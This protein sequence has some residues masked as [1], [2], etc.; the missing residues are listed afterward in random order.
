L[1]ELQNGKNHFLKVDDQEWPEILEKRTLNGKTY[2]GPGNKFAYSGSIGPRHYKENGLATK[3]P[4]LDIDCNDPDNIKSL[5]RL[6]R[7]SGIGYTWQARE[8]GSPAITVRMLDI[9]RVDPEYRENGILYY[10]NIDTELDI[11]TKPLPDRYGIFKVLKG[12][13]APRIFKFQVSWSKNPKSII[14][15]AGNIIKTGLPTKINQGISDLSSLYFDNCH[16]PP[17]VAWDAEGKSIE[18]KKSIKGNI[19][20]EEVIIPEDFDAWPITV[21]TDVEYQVGASENDG[22]IYNSS[23]N[24][25]VITLS[26]GNSGII[27]SLYARWTNIA[28]PQNT[29]ILAAKIQYK[30]YANQSSTTCRTRIY[31][32]DAD[33]AANPTDA[34]DYNNKV[35]TT[36]YTDWTIGT[37]T[38]G[39]WY[40]TPDLTDEVQEVINRE[41]W[42]SGNAMMVLHKNNGSDS[43]AV[44]TIYSYDQTGNVSGPKLLITYDIR[45]YKTLTSAVSSL[46][47]INR[48][49]ILTKTLT[50]IS[51][52]TGSLFC[53]YKRGKVLVA[54]VAANGSISRKISKRVIASI[55]AISLIAKDICKIII[56][57][58]NLISGIGKKGYKDIVARIISVG[59]VIKHKIILKDLVASVSVVGLIDR[60]IIR[61]KTL[62]AN[63]VSNI[64][65]GRKISKFM[66][67]AVKATSIFNTVYT[68]IITLGGHLRVKPELMIKK[69]NDGNLSIANSA[70]TGTFQFTG[71]S[72]DEEIFVHNDKEIIVSDLRDN[73]YSNFEGEFL[74]L[75]VGDNTLTIEG[76]SNVKLR[77]REKYFPHGS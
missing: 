16:L 14:T 3:E 30:A 51:S 53:L 32:N 58:I 23:F 31:F 12:E 26:V 33:D 8:E 5:Y 55:L 24:N 37:W 63:I 18:V 42:E 29:T 62:V 10:S 2:N 40:D 20:T 22:F 1:H 61:G 27:A 72:S 54:S 50:A 43:S 75:E 35:V 64:T 60:I 56:A 59:S 39:E 48:Y 76:V 9:P 4:F 19:L 73:P 6:T 34:T 77:W 69:R 15:K 7:T 45:Y 49:R 44:R 38:E 13:K 36:A 21:D 52:A 74:E 71:L 47:N 57:N 11:Y 46:G 66:S 41:G 28:I 17:C 25:N 70:T 65:I 67:A 68:I